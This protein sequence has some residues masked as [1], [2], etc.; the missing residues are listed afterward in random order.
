MSWIFVGLWGLLVGSVAANLFQLLALAKL[1]GLHRVSWWKAPA[2]PNTLA[3]LR[4]HS[5]HIDAETGVDHWQGRWDDYAGRDGR[6]DAAEAVTDQNR[7]CWGH[8]TDYP[9]LEEGQK[10]GTAVL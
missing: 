5:N 7:P 8:W 2:F 3:N 4:D 1:T 10:N 6:F 9:V